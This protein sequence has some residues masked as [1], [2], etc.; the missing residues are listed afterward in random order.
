MKLTQ[1]R[2]TA[3][4]AQC[5]PLIPARRLIRLMAPRYGRQH[6]AGQDG[7]PL[8]SCTTQP[9]AT[10]TDEEKE[11]ENARVGQELVRA[12]AKL[13]SHQFVDRLAPQIFRLPVGSCGSCKLPAVVGSTDA[14]QTGV[15]NGLCCGSKSIIVRVVSAMSGRVALLARLPL[16]SSSC[17]GA[18]NEHLMKDLF[19]NIKVAIVITA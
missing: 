14:V 7:K 12:W 5:L 15:F 17:Y 8:S 1:A 10:S 6:Y 4:E 13:L 3:P 11:K 9:Q 16:K 18:G 2:G 19:Q